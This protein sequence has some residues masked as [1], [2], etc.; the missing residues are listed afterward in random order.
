MPRRTLLIR[1]AALLLVCGLMTGSLAS[2]AQEPAATWQSTLIWQPTLVDAGNALAAHVNQID[3]A[4]N[5]DVDPVFA[6]NGAG[7]EGAVYAFQV[8]WSCPA[9]NANPA[10]LTWQA[11]MIWDPT[12][13]GAAAA[14]T[15]HLNQTEATC[16]V[17][18]DN[19]QSAN[20]AGPEGVVYA[21]L[22]TWAC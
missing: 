11:A 21:F 22:V 3:A 12:L 15:S 18:V 10:G 17:D 9:T 8:S 6:T 19:V 7:P 16:R 20:G 5:V 2:S 4:C 1:L 14:L 13:E